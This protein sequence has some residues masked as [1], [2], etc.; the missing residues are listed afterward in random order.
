MGHRMPDIMS[1]LPRCWSLSSHDWLDV[2][3]YQSHSNDPYQIFPEKK[4]DKQEILLLEE[5]ILL[6]AVKSLCVRVSEMNKKWY[7][8]RVRGY[9]IFT[10]EKYRN[11]VI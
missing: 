1:G 10:C 2:A 4:K 8:H 3:I 5:F 11:M 6:Q 7:F 9:T